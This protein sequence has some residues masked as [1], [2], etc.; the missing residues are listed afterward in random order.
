MN[1]NSMK[2]A[3]Y[4]WI[5]SICFVFANEMS[6]FFRHALVCLPT[7]THMRQKDV[8]FLHSLTK[9]IWMK[10]QAVDRIAS[11][12]ILEQ[13]WFTVKNCYSM[14]RVRRSRK[15]IAASVELFAKWLCASAMFLYYNFQP[16]LLILSKI[17]RIATLFAIRNSVYV[18]WLCSYR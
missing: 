5:G 9:F 4:T 10:E 7:F 11:S 8:L 3:W 15:I 16:C 18:H 12:T 13:T 1:L 17:E 2:I 6:H 14:Y